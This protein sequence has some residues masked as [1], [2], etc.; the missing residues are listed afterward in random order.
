LRQITKWNDPALLK[1]NPGLPD[2]PITP[3]CRDESSGTTNIFTEY[4]SKRSP[5]FAKEF[6]TSKKPK[7]PSGVNAKQGNAGIAEA[8]KNTPNTI[9]Y[10]E[11]AFAKQNG[12]SYAT[13]VNKA[14]KDVKPGPATVTAAVDAALLA[15]KGGEPYTLHPLAFSFTDAGGDDAYPIVGASYAILYRKQPKDKGPVVV[16]FLRWATGDGQKFAA[17]LDYAPLP[18]SLT[19][20]SHEQLNTVTFE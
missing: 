19:R 12:I 14:G 8:V 16:E 9:G 11:L 5:E 20:M 1:L 6:G 7:W 18:Q 13:L 3:F 2:K 17:E 10:V 4:L 15:P